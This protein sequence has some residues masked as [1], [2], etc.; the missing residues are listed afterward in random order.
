MAGRAGS[1]FF[2]ISCLLLCLCL[3]LCRSTRAL[4]AASSELDASEIEALGLEEEDTKAHSADL[5]EE[6]FGEDDFPT[7]GGEG[8]GGGEG[9]DEDG[10]PT[11][12]GEGFGADYFPNG[13]EEDEDDF[14]SFS[15]SD[16]D[17]VVLSLGNFSE[18]LAANHYVMVKFYAPW[19]GHCR[20]VAPEYARAAIELK[21][22]GA[23]L[24][25][26]DVTVESELAEQY[27]VRGLPT[28]LFFIDGKPKPYSYHRTSEAL[29][30]WIQRK[31]GPV[32][33]EVNSTSEAKTILE[34]GNTVVV[35]LFDKFEGKEID[36]FTSAAR[37]EDNVLFYYTKNKEVAELFHIKQDSKVPFAV[38]LKSAA[39][40]VVSYGGDFERSSISDFVLANK[41][42]LVSIFNHDS[43]TS[44]FESSIKKQIILFASP[45]DSK[46]VFPAFEE[47]AKF[48]KGKLLF[49]YVDSSSDEVGK[50]VVEFFGASVEK[51]MIMAFMV[52]EDRPMKYLLEDEPTVEKIKDFATRFLAGKLKQFYKSEPLP[53]KNDGDVKVV[54][55]KNFDEIVLDESKDV[56]LEIYATW[57]G[58][59]Q[60]LEPTYN[61]LGK[62]LRGI[63]S[64]VIAKMDGTKNEHPR[65][66]SDGYPTLLFYPAGNKTIDAMTVDIEWTIKTFYQF[67]K[68][69]AAIPF[70]LAKPT[71]VG[72]ETTKTDLKEDTPQSIGQMSESTYEPK[73]EL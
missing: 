13:R 62:V 72:E 15:I 60:T 64:L 19:C 30:A 66:K 63:D 18:F 49:I 32:I 7:G 9:F 33:T 56:L 53:E 71:T 26:V 35:A 46:L 69:N 54:V 44:I 45:E 25:K 10:F 38:L 65:A 36:E 11:G 21:A 6:E 24:A 17:V 48:H 29:V 2:H 34:S 28:L 8:L 70:T 43:A 47:A 67:L 52:S 58:H 3:L 20:A 1:G 51:P 16:P 41:L 12:A 61:K 40:K 42:P 23:Y 31:V 22:S 5:N 14:W 57:C 37:Q 55:G 39:E 68:K 50:P 27:D 73:D 59:C 4:E